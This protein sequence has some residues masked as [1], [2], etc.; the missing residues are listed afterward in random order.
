MRGILQNGHVTLAP[1][2]SL[3]EGRRS[4]GEA[5]AGGREGGGSDGGCG[6]DS[7]DG[8]GSCCWGRVGDDGLEDGQSLGSPIM[9]VRSVDGDSID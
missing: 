2:R 6:C 9:M 3:G 4:R 5:G 7:R 1:G 8:R